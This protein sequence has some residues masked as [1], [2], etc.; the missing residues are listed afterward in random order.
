MISI[1]S[2][3]YSFSI[4]T[5]SRGHCFRHQR[6]APDVRKQHR[7]HRIAALEDIL[8]AREQPIDNLLCHV[9]RHRVAH[10]LFTRDVL[11][12]EHVADRIARGVEE[13]RHR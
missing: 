7:G 9:P 2:V 13:R 12:H 11:E 6:E 5:V 3:K 10:A 8:A 4:D 1:I